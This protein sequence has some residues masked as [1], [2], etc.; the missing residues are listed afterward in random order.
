MSFCPLNVSWSIRIH[1]NW[2]LAVQ[3]KAS[4]VEVLL[5]TICD[6]THDCHFNVSM[7]YLNTWSLLVSTLIVCERLSAMDYHIPL[8]H[9]TCQNFWFKFPWVPPFR[10]FRNVGLDYPPPPNENLSRSLHF[11]FQLVWS[12][13]PPLCG[14]WCV[15]TNRCIPQ[16]YRFVQKSKS[17][18]HRSQW[19]HS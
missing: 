13:P 3:L 15:E 16:G 1:C 6:W 12:N 8:P 18:L 5:F 17:E 19:S 10:Y 2:L 14:S 11:R 9:S 7:N 4:E